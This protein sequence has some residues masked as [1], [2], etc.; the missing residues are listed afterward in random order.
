ML[1]TNE[2]SQIQSATKVTSDSLNDRMNSFSRQLKHA[3]FGS[4]SW[5][6]LIQIISSTVFQ[7]FDWKFWNLGGHWCLCVLH[8]TIISYN[9]CSSRLTLTVWTSN[10][11]TCVL[12]EN[13][14][15]VLRYWMFNRWIL[16]RLKI[17]TTTVLETAI[18]FYDETPTQS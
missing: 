1:K 3:F 17:V 2:I 5:K 4:L 7:C 15:C 6:S 13:S 18:S 8:F 14:V 16:V 12:L 10:I 9:I 11:P